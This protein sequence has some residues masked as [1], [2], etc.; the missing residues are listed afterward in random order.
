M[1]DTEKK[2]KYLIFVDGA[3]VELRREVKGKG[4]PPKG[5]TANEEGNFIVPP[6]SVSKE[7]VDYVTLDASGKEVGR[8]TK[9]RGRTKPG[10]VLATEGQYKGHYVKTETAAST[11]PVAA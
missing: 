3:G 8:A 7:T 2:V 10:Y 9:S 5:A 11:E 6:Q 4:R 1:A